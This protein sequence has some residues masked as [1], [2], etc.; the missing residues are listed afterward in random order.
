MPHDNLS[1]RSF[2]DSDARLTK[3]QRTTLRLLDAAEPLFA[4]Q[5]YHATSL[6]S[7]AQIAGIREPG[8]Y[9][10]FPNK[11]SLYASTIERAL[12]PLA[13]AMQAHLARGD[14]ALVSLP[15]VVI[16]TLAAHTHV[17]SLFQ[18]V[19]QG[20]A[21]L[22]EVPQVRDWLAAVFEQ[23]A[24]ALR[25]V[26]RSDLDNE[27][28]AIRIIAMLTLC[29]DFFLSRRSFDLLVDGDI[30][31]AT[32]IEREKRLIARVQGALLLD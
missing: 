28:V 12:A 18:Q 5:G 27:E 20:S 17:P 21:D 10:H 14:D 1:R 22:P 11:E 19:L 29:T 32:N 2:P 25:R 16:D 6:R 4:K 3:G 13:D 15:G 8:I 26:G 30:T 23:S 7:I 31:S 9:N 24:D